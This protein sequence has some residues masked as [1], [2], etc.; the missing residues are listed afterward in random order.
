MKVPSSFDR[1]ERWATHQINPY[2]HLPLR[3]TTPDY[4]GKTD[5]YSRAKVTIKKWDERLESALPNFF[6]Q[7]RLDNFGKEIDSWAQQSRG[8]FHIKHPGI[9]KHS[10][11]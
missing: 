4:R 1:F 3:P 5:W 7:T 6:W 2:K 11:L 8:F 10:N 9:Y